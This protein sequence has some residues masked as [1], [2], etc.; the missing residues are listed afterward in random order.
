MISVTC[1]FSP[2]PFCCQRY[3]PK[4]TIGAYYYSSN[5]SFSPLLPGWTLISPAGYKG[6]YHLLF[7]L[8]PGL[9][10][11]T[12]RFTV[13][14]SSAVPS[15]NQSDEFVPVFQESDLVPQFSTA[16]TDT[17]TPFSVPSVSL[18]RSSQFSPPTRL[19]FAKFAHQ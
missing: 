1:R 16:V 5:S 12:H 8:P 4:R 14:P 17:V 19:T 7:C 9:S 3:F 13:L 18:S 6:L 11:F 15:S 2:Y 10:S